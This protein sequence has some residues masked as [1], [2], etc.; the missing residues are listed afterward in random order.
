MIILSER[1]WTFAQLSTRS[2]DGV[3]W[4]EHQ[5]LMMSFYMMLLTAFLRQNF[6]LH[7]CHSPYLEGRCNIHPKTHPGACLS[8]WWF[9]SK[10][11][12]NVQKWNTSISAFDQDFL[13]GLSY[14]Y[15]GH[16]IPFIVCLTVEKR[17]RWK[18]GTWK[19]VSGFRWFRK[20]YMN[21]RRDMVP[22]P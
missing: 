13:P 15:L 7:L 11:Q 9:V 8:V 12:T 4:R 21:D 2:P 16:I 6:L 20:K 10:A 3:T 18:Y 14:T 19:I 1:S 17:G 22:Q 5:K